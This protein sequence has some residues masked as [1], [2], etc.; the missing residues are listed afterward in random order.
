MSLTISDIDCIKRMWSQFIIRRQ[1]TQQNSKYVN[2]KDLKRDK[3]AAP[4][5]ATKDNIC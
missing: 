5:T 1:L 2:L 4:Q 3:Q